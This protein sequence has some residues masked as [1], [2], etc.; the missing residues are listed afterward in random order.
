MSLPN[1]TFNKST[2]GLGQALPGKDH[3]SGFLFYS[4]TL[5]SGFAAD[6]RVKQVFSLEEAENLGV[7]TG[8]AFD[9]YHYHI[10]E[11]F[12]I[13]PKG[14]L[15]VGFYAVPVGTYDFAEL[16]TMRLF[17]E[18]Q[19][20][21]FGVYVNDEAYTTTEVTALQAEVTKSEVANQP[22]EVLYAADISGTADLST[23][24]D[25]TALSAPGVSVV[26]GQDGGAT[27]AAL[28][29]T[30]TYSVCSVGTL[31][32]A[33][34]LAKVSESIAWVEKFPLVTGAEL[35]VAAFGNGDLFRDKTDAFLDSLNDNGYIFL[36]K[37]TDI[38]NTYFS[39]SKTAVVATNDFSSI[40]INRSYHKAVRNINS[41]I[42][43][44]LNSPITVN[45]DG[46]LTTDVIVSYKTLASRPLDDMV[47]S[48]ELSAF[49]V[50]VDPAQ[51]V[52]STST[53]VL[54]VKLVPVGV[55]REIVFNIGFVTSIS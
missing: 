35:D 43:P 11:Y 31:L 21:Q 20:R 26:I 53:I 17:A 44:K 12:R 39:D 47:N 16:E 29:V 23:L 27:G 9:V 52:L 32:G 15:F 36:R 19:I 2:G 48:G 38:A 1:I 40:E 55:A 37:F 50:I 13:Q 54:T 42:K 25:L 30:L 49:S 4:A 7:I 6:D 41:I 51:D 18:G 34:S 28:A 22:F 8:G 14:V 3:Y 45:A 46:T 5:P 24:A 33:V 10:S